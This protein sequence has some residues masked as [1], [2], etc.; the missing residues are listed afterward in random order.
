MDILQHSWEDVQF[1]TNTI[2]NAYRANNKDTFQNFLGWT[3]EDKVFVTQ[4]SHILG[5]HK[6]E[7]KTNA[8]INNFMKIFFLANDLVTQYNKVVLSDVARL[9]CYDAAIDQALHTDY[10]HYSE[11]A[12]QL[13]KR[14]RS[15]RGMAK[16]SAYRKDLRNPEL[17]ERTQLLIRTR[18][19]SDFINDPSNAIDRQ[20]ES[21]KQDYNSQLAST[22]TQ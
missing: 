9:K 10:E 22:L 20:R 11:Y 16:L 18:L 14:Y 21:L 15:Y 2:L 5:Y 17:I 4:L 19:L 8:Y 7:K 13:K 1:R 3:Q 12:S 6:F